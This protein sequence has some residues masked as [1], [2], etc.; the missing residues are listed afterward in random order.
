MGMIYLVRKKL[1]QTKADLHRLLMSV[2]AK[3]IVKS[4]NEVQV[5]D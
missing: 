3:A 1:F 4:A 2:C 5:W